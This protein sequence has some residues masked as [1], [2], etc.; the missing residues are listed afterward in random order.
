MA[1]PAGT[2]KTKKI[3]QKKNSEKP[4]KLI[5]I[6]TP[7]CLMCGKNGNQSEFYNSYN[8][9]YQFNSSKIPYC[10]DC[11]QK[12]Y[13]EYYKKT[14]D[15]EIAMYYLCRKL[16]IYF[17]HS[18][19]EGASKAVL[20]GKS[21]IPEYIRIYNGFHDSAKYGDNFSQSANFLDL[22]S[23]E[24]KYKTDLSVTVGKK[25]LDY[26]ENNYEDEISKNE[27]IKLLGY[28]PFF[29]YPEQ[30]KQFLYNT[31][32]PFLDDATLEDSFKL[33]IVIEMVKSLNQIERLNKTFNNLMA[34]TDNI[35]EN[36][37]KISNLVGAKDK[38]YKSILAM[39]KDNGISVNYANNKSQG[40]GTLSKI[41]KDLEDIGLR[42]AKVNLFDIE[43]SESMKQVADISN[44][45][46]IDQ[47]NLQESELWDMIKELRDVRIK[48]DNE[49]SKLNE[50][51]RLEKV[52][53]ADLVE[54][55]NQMKEYIDKLDEKYNAL[56]KSKYIQVDN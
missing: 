14:G 2:N 25:E 37:G 22:E 33:P 48:L 41:I 30:D 3:T 11:I 56:K 44:R 27:V 32:L 39:A 47:M 29:D 49:V 45:S 51:L 50:E 42:E 15:S 19:F 9:T 46:I 6:Y 26:I 31:L 52:K 8:L 1:R 21:L 55:Q 18:I 10:K 5:P 43:T 36:S 16:D 28:D 34:S 24:K 7:L 54:I 40:A 12:L 17:S 23:L 53:N 4:S 13:E 38:L 35:E 20:K